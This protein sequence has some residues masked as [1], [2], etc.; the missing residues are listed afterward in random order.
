MSLLERMHRE[1]HEEV[2][3][4][5]DE[6]ADYRAIFAI[7][8][9][10]RGPAMGG[11][12]LWR[13]DREEDALADA[14]G[15]ARAMTFKAAAAD[16]PFG[17]GKAVVLARGPGDWPSDRRRLF[18]AHGRAVERLGGRYLTGPD[19]GSSAEDMLAVA[20]RTRFVGCF[21]GHEGDPAPH[22]ARGVLRAMLAAAE[23]RWG[24]PSLAGRRVLVQGCGNV[25]AALARL[26]RAEGATLLVADID[27]VR[28]A[29]VAASLG[30]TIVAPDAALGAE[31]DVFAPC[32]LGGVLDSR[33]IARLRV[34][35]VA[36]AAN[37]PLAAPEHAALLRARG[38]T[39]V[40]DYVANA[41]GLIS[42]A[43][44]LLGW[45]HAERDARVDA[46]FETTRA[47]LVAA[48][49]ERITPWAAAERLVA[50]RLAVAAPRSSRA[51]DAEPHCAA[52]GAP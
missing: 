33:A 19:V 5:R 22:T 10:R 7:H 34:A 16:L 41:G 35:I 26:V 52:T 14:L 18:H 46:I 2:V 21:L 9:T 49:R 8:S 50:E 28:A 24:T 32:A 3:F 4:T 43:A 25:G 51:P 47:L 37:C 39:G 23:H 40:P 12:R 44:T 48:E 20:E 31:A 27:A 42:G 13:Y 38:I 29:A 6:G 11:T 36:G 17:G 45:S 15:L 30:A 1:G